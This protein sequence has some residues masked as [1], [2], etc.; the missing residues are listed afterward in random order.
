M[1]PDRGR[2]QLA[3]SWRRQQ[4][5]D[6]CRWM[7]T[8]RGTGAALLVVSLAL[9]AAAHC[10]PIRVSV[11]SA[12]V[13]GDQ[14]SVFSAISGDGRYMVFM[15]S[16]ANL[17]ADDTNGVP[18]VFRHDGSTGETVRVSVGN[19]GTQGN[20]AASS[21]TLS[22]D[23]RYVAFISEAS[24]LVAGDTN[25]FSDVFVRDCELGTTERVNVS[26]GGAQAVGDDAREPSISPDGRYV[27]FHSS[28]GDLV[29]TPI[30]VADQVFRHD[31]ETEETILV[32]AD[33]SGNAG[34]LGSG[35][36]SVSSGGRYVA[37]SSAS[38][39]L[40]PGDTN[41]ASDV[42]VR[43]CATGR[44]SRVSLG[45]G[46][47]QGNGGSRAS[48]QG[49]SDD[50]KRIVFTSSATNLVSG[51]TNGE[52]DVFVHDRKAGTTARASVGDSG[53]QADGE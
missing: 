41:A 40:V 20:G 48:V 42:F 32:S 50:G 15:S 6:S 13:Q 5:T 19:T 43:D 7:C 24:N 2:T 21:P 9:C 30:G 25:G 34:N 14:D 33:N 51:D 16:A 53:Q 29:T 28:A 36:P 27:V 38:T 18:D 1:G 52:V 31:R 17:V 22:A 11:S 45:E 10:A 26:T 47:A 37:F 39:N 35:G 46:G 3:S 8:K 49:I 4:P 12:G 44:T 23:G